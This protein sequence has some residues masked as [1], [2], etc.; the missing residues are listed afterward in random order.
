M[1]RYCVS[2]QEADDLD[3]RGT[4]Y[5]A[6]RSENT[7]MNHTHTEGVSDVLNVRTQE[8]LDLREYGICL[9]NEL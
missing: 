1:R 2:N 6:N 5:L 9:M 3:S 7:I 4:F 8:C